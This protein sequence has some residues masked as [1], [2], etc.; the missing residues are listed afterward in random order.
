[1]IDNQAAR[2]GDDALGF[3]RDA[4]Q[5]VQVP[6]REDVMGDALRTLGIDAKPQPPAPPAEVSSEQAA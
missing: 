1:M 5:A 2:K 3:L 4:V 6:N